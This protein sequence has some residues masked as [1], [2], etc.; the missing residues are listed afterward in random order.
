MHWAEYI[1]H[2]TLHF[3]IVLSFVLA[4]V[5]VWWVR[6]EDPRLATFVRWTGWVTLAMASAT[7]L[8]GIVAAPGILG[9][10]G[11][12]GLSDHRNMG[13]LAWCAIAI[14]TIAFEV[15]T[16]AGQRYVRRFAALCWIA[17]A[18]AVVGAGHWGG[19]AL[20]SDKIPWQGTRPI[21]SPEEPSPTEP[22]GV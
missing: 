10:D 16:R 18:V 6:T 1:H 9:G 11:P 8:S 2:V 4:V 15:G 13:V 20:H 7:M 12:Q 5:G 17:A 14:A 21:L 22:G 3:P 19:S